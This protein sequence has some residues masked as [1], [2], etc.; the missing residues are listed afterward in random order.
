MGHTENKTLSEL[1]SILKD[2]IESFEINKAT[3]VYTSEDYKISNLRFS[4]KKMKK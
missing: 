2:H 4:I 1:K 3:G